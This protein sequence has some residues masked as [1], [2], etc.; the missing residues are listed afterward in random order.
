MP[1][2]RKSVAEICCDCAHLS[3]APDESYPFITA[4]HAL[5]HFEDPIDVVREWFRVIKPGGVLGIV[6][7]DTRYTPK[8]GTK[9]HDDTHKSEMDPETFERKVL[10]PFLELESRATLLSFCT[11]NNRWSYECVIRKAP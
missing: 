11:L 2:G 8:P 4:I 7:P 5:E 9:S 1:W 3:F 6:C 10:R